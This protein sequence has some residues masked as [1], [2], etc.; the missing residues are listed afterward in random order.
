MTKRTLSEWVLTLWTSTY[1][2][3]ITSSSFTTKYTEMSLES[4]LDLAIFSILL[5][6]SFEITMFFI[7]TFAPG[8]I[9]ASDFSGVL[10]SLS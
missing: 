5:F 1:P 6:C 3:A 10:K 7:T 9:M 4:S 8:N 2:Y